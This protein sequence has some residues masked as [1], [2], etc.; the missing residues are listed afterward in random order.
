MTK[1]SL[2]LPL[3][4][5]VLASLPGCDLLLLGTTM[6][7]IAPGLG[8][9]L[10]GKVVDSLTGLPIG[11]ATVTAGWGS[12]NSDGAG[13][14]SLYDDFSGG[15]ILSISRAGYVSSTYDQGPVVDGTTYY[16]DPSFSTT[17]DLTHRKVNLT[18]TLLNSD[19]TPMKAN[20][21]VTFAGAGSIRTNTVNG[22]YALG[23]NVGLP[24]GIF[25][26]VLAGGQ[27]TGGPAMPLTPNDLPQAFSYQSFGYRLV[28]V[29]STTDSSWNA[30]ADLTI[31]SAQAIPIFSMGVVYQG[32]DSFSAPNPQ[33]EVSL[34][35][36]LL[37]TV[38]V[39]RQFSSNQSI[40]VPQ[41]A[42]VK[43]VIG[44]TVSD[45]SGKMK[46]SVSIT[47]SFRPQVTFNLLAPPKV[48]GPTDNTQRAGANPTFSWNPVP[49]ADSYVVEVLEDTG[50]PVPQAK[51]RGY[52][53][54]TSLRYPGFWDNDYNGG[55]L[56][57]QA[58]YSWAVHAVAARVDG[59]GASDM[60]PQLPRGLPT[61]TP[62]R[63]SQFESVT[64]GMRFTR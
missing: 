18:G 36:G 32:L 38:I 21:N 46:S 2:L 40:P 42:G 41:V 10:K 44:G 3:T 33:T 15:K 62:F 52:T 23:L 39:A 20:G 55:A 34:D 35:F 8:H 56:Y 29:P 6:P 1:H 63:Q 9:P 30:T 58:S 4:I 19:G 27:I 60:G 37:G 26:G 51:W 12:T 59:V 16:L 57:A 13:N 24:G 7:G 25:S 43:Y 48:I 53:T 31:Q 14:F 5:L 64:S 22:Q 28:D 17:T 50:S 49:K 54:H 47:S 61:E 11:R 45:A